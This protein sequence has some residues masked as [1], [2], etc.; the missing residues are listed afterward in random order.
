MKKIR[1]ERRRNNRTGHSFTYFT[2]GGPAP[3]YDYFDNM[4]A[5]EFLDF[6]RG[7]E[8]DNAF[9][10]FAERVHIELLKKELK[11]LRPYRCPVEAAEADEKG[12]NGR[13]ISKVQQILRT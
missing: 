2:G 3:Q 1:L 4:G 11:G 12:L 9:R 8:A 10:V 6:L 7:V 13:R 5:E